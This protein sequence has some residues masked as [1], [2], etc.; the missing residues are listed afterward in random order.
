MSGFYFDL[1]SQLAQA[2]C[3]SLAA[4]FFV[5]FGNIQESVLDLDRSVL[6]LHGGLAIVGAEGRHSVV[7]LSQVT[8]IRKHSS[9]RLL[10][11]KRLSW[12]QLARVPE[13]SCDWSLER[14]DGSSALGSHGRDLIRDTVVRIWVWRQSGLALGR[15]AVVDRLILRL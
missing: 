7:S 1:V 4:V 12:L 8:F 10:G 6:I 9:S 5:D 2:E 11:L 3:C 14:R 13:L 15:W